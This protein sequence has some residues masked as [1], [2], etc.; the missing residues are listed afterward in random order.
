MIVAP[1]ALPSEDQADP[2]LLKL[3]KNKG[4]LEK[5]VSVFM[6][7]CK[8]KEKAKQEIKIYKQKKISSE[9]ENILNKVAESPKETYKA[10]L[11]PIT[12]ELDETLSE[13][14]LYGICVKPIWHAVKGVGNLFMRCL[15]F[16][17]RS[18]GELIQLLNQAAEESMK[19]AGQN[20]DGKVKEVM[21]QIHE[22]AENIKNTGVKI[23]KLGQQGIDKNKQKMAQIPSNAGLAPIRGTSQPEYATWQRKHIKDEK[24]HPE[25]EQSNHGSAQSTHTVDENLH[26]E[27]KKEPAHEN[28]Q[29]PHTTGEAISHGTEKPEKPKL[30]SQLFAVIDGVQPPYTND[31]IDHRETDKS[32]EGHLQSPHTDEENAQA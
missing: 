22:T 21:S 12:K 32:K 2:Q 28:G 23:D 10:V 24:V 19:A 25:I 27:S 16:S 13:Y 18:T 3:F 30:P 15:G 14:K 4:N 29:S 6:I 8:D 31:E 9:L 20:P 1:K 7:A 5:L 26:S 11:K 17:V